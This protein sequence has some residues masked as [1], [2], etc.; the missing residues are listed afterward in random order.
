MLL[1]EFLLSDQEG[2]DAFKCSADGPK[3]ELVLP[4]Y[5][6]HVVQPRLG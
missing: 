2:K 1:R 4:E 3:N 5:V 6:T